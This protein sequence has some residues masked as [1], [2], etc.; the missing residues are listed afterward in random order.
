MIVNNMKTKQET[1]NEILTGAAKNNNEIS[2]VRVRHTESVHALD[3]SCELCLIAR[4]KNIGPSG[5]DE[6]KKDLDW[7]DSNKPTP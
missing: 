4:H 7:Y 5:E 6:I 1:N 3:C 2:E